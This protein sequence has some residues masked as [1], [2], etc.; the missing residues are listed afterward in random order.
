MGIKIDDTGDTV[1]LEK[2]LSL[3]LSL[4]VSLALYLP[5]P[6]SL[7]VYLS[8]SLSPSFT[9]HLPFYLSFSVSLFSLPFSFFLFHCIIL[10]LSLSLSLSLYFPFFLSV[11]PFRTD[12]VNETYRMSAEIISSRLVF[13]D[14]KLQ[15]PK[16]PR[17]AK[18]GWESHRG[19]GRD[20]I[21]YD[22]DERS[23]FFRM[24]PA[25]AVLRYDKRRVSTCVGAITLIQARL[26]YV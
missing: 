15:P 12:R 26:D 21:R 3:S 22:R 16:S 13:V 7:S 11:S 25:L 14:R 10:F 19:G 9:L 17:N 1:E 23:E 6:L 2:V 24:Q 5:L 20:E 18:S 8:L 4:P